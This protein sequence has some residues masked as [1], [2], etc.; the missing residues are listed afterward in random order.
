MYLFR[1]V[2]HGSTTTKQIITGNDIQRTYTNGAYTVDSCY[3]PNLN[4]FAY[5]TIIIPTYTRIKYVMLLGLVHSFFAA[6]IVM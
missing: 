4:R 3:I 1:Y 2:L 5:N 6:G